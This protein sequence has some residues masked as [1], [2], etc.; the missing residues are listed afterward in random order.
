MTPASAA[1]CVN[2]ALRTKIEQ[3]AYALRAKENP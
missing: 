2:E 3:R 1:P